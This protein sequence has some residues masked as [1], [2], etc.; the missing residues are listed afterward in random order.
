MGLKFP[1]VALCDQGS[2]NGD[3]AHDI[4]GRTMSNTVGVDP[5]KH[6]LVLALVPEN[7]T[8]MPP[9][10]KPSD[11]GP[12]GLGKLVELL[13]AHF[14]AH[15]VRCVAVVQDPGRPR[16][17]DMRD[18]AHLEAA[19]AMACYRTG[20]RLEWLTVGDAL[21]HLGLDAKGGDRKGRLRQLLES[22]LGAD[23]LSPDPDRRAA[24]LGIALVSA[25]LDVEAL[26]ES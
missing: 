20:A 18:R 14:T 11:R 5:S 4:V 22:T 26:F 13:A 7:S 12:N 16:P 1:L 25:G 19:V 6:D 15:E 24:A 3:G 17:T 8:D 9:S 2:A 10:A 21:R 23:R